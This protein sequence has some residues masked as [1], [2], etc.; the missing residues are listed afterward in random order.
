MDDI[1]RLYPKNGTDEVALA[2]TE[3]AIKK[4][5]GLTELDSYR[6]VNDELLL[7]E[8]EIDDKVGPT[9]YPTMGRLTFLPATQGT[10][11]TR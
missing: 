2:K 4:I 10:S 5:T 3:A 6:D 7:W 11:R 9:F 1:N 8:V